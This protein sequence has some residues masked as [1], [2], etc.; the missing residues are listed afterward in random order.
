MAASS[1]ATEKAELVERYEKVRR[2]LSYIQAALAAQI[3]VANNE[4]DQE[5]SDSL[6]AYRNLLNVHGNAII[7]QVALIDA[8]IVAIHAACP[9]SLA[10]L[11]I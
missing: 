9:P 11:V 2:D 8:L 4:P 5:V 1:I 3:N 7:D 6:K 10:P